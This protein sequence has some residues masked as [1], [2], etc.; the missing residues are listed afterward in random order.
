MFSY[1]G[2]RHKKKFVRNKCFKFLLMSFLKFFNCRRRHVAMQK[3]SIVKNGQVSKI[4]K[5]IGTQM[6]AMKKKEKEKDSPCSLAKV[7]SKFQTRETC[8]KE[9]SKDSHYIFHTHAHLDLRV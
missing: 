9:H 8:F 6:L 3:K 4:S 1:T 5:A 7:F 2:R